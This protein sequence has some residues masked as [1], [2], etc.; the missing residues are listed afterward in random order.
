MSPLNGYFNPSCYLSAVEYWSDS[1]NHV[2]MGDFA[3]GRVTDGVNN[4]NPGNVYETIYVR[5]GRNAVPL[6]GTLALVGLGL[7][8]AGALRRKS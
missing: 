7:L 4:T 6:P 5:D 2:D 3:A 8:G 1:F